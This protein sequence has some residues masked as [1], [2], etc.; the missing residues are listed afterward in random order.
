M[1]AATAASACT[2]IPHSLL[3][4]CV[5]HCVSQVTRLPVRLFVDD[6][7]LDVFPPQQAD[8][9][10]SEIS[11]EEIYVVPADSEGTSYQLA[12]P[13]QKLVFTV[14]NNRDIPLLLKPTS[15][16]VGFSID[17]EAAVHRPVPL[18]EERPAALPSE[19]NLLMSPRSALTSLCTSTLSR[20]CQFSPCVLTRGLKWRRT[21]A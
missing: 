21:C 11:F 9:S 18:L 6:D 10:S 3:R 8:T 4:M 17:C 14:R 15:N 2:C 16:I 5:G 13:A 19:S 20:K 7:S 12:H 1:Y